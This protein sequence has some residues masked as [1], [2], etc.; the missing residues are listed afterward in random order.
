[1]FTIESLRTSMLLILFL[2]SIFFG[3]AY[4]K[5]PFNKDISTEKTAVAFNDICAAQL[6]VIK[7]VTVKGVYSFSMKAASGLY[8][9]IQE[10]DDNISSHWVG[11][12]GNDFHDDKLASEQ[13]E[14]LLTLAYL[15][16]M[17]VDICLLEHTYP[18]VVFGI[19]LH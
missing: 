16:Q 7:E 1:M 14:F 9:E 11:K 6:G 3:A 12:S 5:S 19:R 10:D 2:S 8:I 15:N 17:N 4:A 18:S 13:T